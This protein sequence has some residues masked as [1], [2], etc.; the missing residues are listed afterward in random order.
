VT[1]VGDA[2][3]VSGV[4]DPANITRALSEAGLYLT[5]LTPLS[6][7]LESVFLDLTTEH[8]QVSA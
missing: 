4:T 2:L 1:A 3:Q 6:A 7:D 8:A 5:E